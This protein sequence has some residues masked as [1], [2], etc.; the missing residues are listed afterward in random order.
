MNS[1]CVRIPF[2]EAL[3][4]RRFLSAGGATL[5]A[6]AESLSAAMVV[7]L[8]KVKLPRL[9]GQWA[10]TGRVGTA[11]YSALVTISKQSATGALTGTLRA[12]KH[13]YKLTGQVLADRT[14]KLS[15]KAKGVSGKMWGMVSANA[16]TM[17]GKFQIRDLDTVSGS[18]TLK[19]R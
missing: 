10:G 5:A 8:S 17:S 16:N 12:S 7:S 4:E 1:R 13:V 19:R 15:W 11:K 14:F 18:V 3:E 2:V 6:A 9:I